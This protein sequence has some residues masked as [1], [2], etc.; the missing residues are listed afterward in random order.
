[1]KKAKKEIDGAAFA[2]ELSD[3]KNAK[4]IFS[5]LGKTMKTDVLRNRMQNVSN[6]D[7]VVK[8][9]AA[10][11]KVNIQHNRRTSH[12]DCLEMAADKYHRITAQ[13]ISRFKMELNKYCTQKE[14]YENKVQNKETKTVT[15]ND[16]LKQRMSEQ[17]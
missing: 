4:E 5:L 17:R 2:K 11:A 7:A 16:I 1:M 6:M 14:M 8:M 9:N 12:Q 3:C 15:V 13:P 10:I